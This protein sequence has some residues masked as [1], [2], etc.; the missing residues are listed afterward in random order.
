V[1]LYL[2]EL[3]EAEAA[4]HP[5]TRVFDSTTITT[6][7]VNICKTAILCNRSYVQ[8]NFF[9]LEKIIELTRHCASDPEWLWDVDQNDF[10]CSVYVFLTQ[11]FV[12]PT[13]QRTV[14]AQFLF[15]IGPVVVANLTELAPCFLSF[16]VQH[17]NGLPCLM[18]DFASLFAKKCSDVWRVWHWVFTRPDARRAFAAFVTATVLVVVKNWVLQSNDGVER[19]FN[20]DAA[21]VAVLSNQE[22]LSE[23]LRFTSYFHE[24]RSGQ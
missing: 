18:G 19:E 17:M 21:S 4:A 8:G 3:L 2:A 22:S 9:I 24:K 20:W 13:T 10:A 1:P 23:I 6:I 5:T 11:F 12:T 14:M 15:D 16:L 7:G